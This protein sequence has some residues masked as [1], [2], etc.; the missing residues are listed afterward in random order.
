MSDPHGALREALHKA[1]TPEQKKR[2]TS[3]T[4]TSL[5]EAIAKHYT[6]EKK[7]HDNDD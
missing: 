3:P 6:P 7:D 2:R 5:D 1:L 4:A